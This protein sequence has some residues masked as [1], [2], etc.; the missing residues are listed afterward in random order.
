MHTTSRF[1]VHEAD[2]V[3]HGVVGLTL[4]STLGV[5]LFAFAALTIG[6][7]MSAFALLL[8]PGL[9]IALARHAER[10]RTVR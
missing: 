9:I 5:A 3:P 4:V 10:N 1:S 6:G 7:V 8:V 2:G